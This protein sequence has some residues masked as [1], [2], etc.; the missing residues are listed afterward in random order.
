V[1]REKML[2]L[3]DSLRALAGAVNIRIES[4]VDETLRSA[5]IELTTAIID[6]LELGGVLGTATAAMVRSS[7]SPP[8]L[9]T[10]ILVPTP[11]Q[12]D[13]RALIESFPTLRRGTD[14]ELLP[15]PGRYPQDYSW[16]PE[17]FAERWTVGSG[18]EI[19]AALFVL[20]VWNAHENWAEYGLT[21]GGARGGF[22]N[23]HTAMG[24][25]DELH[26]AAFLSWASN[27]WW[28]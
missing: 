27:P 9:V 6:N 26:R 21:R 19:D 24:N 15:P 4:G 12:Y 13:L 5:L 11:P 17:P 7:E 16:D 28:L 10:R 3:R 8:T 2:E 14:P 1:N 23:L 20:S 18:G 25:W 22:F